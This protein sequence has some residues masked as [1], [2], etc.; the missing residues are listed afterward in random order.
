MVHSTTLLLLSILASH[1]CA[2]GILF[3]TAQL[4]NKI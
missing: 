1:S 3:G 2:V 4:S